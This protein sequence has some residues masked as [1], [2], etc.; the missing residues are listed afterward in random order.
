MRNSGVRGDKLIQE[1]K[2][3]Y[4]QREEV[5]VCNINNEITASGT[6]KNT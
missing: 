4:C 2:Q 6:I 5:V 1:I 3:L